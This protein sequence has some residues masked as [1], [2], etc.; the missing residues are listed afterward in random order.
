METKDYPKHIKLFIYNW[1]HY[2]LDETALK[3]SNT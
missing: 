3:K 2:K 1:K